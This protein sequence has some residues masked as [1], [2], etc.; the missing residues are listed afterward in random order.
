MEANS[1]A[2]LLNFPRQPQVNG[3][4]LFPG[5]V[6]NNAIGNIPYPQNRQWLGHWGTFHNFE[7]PT[8][9]IWSTAAGA[10]TEE[11]RLDLVFHGDS[12]PGGLV[13]SAYIPTS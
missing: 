5:W 2:F 8:L 13:S 3:R 9:S 10:G 11:V 7:P 6:C 1:H 12:P 4:K